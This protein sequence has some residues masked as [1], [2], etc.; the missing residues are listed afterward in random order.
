MRSREA[1]K[2]PI[3]CHHVKH[4]LRGLIGSDD[5]RRTRSRI[6]ANA[7]FRNVLTFI[8]VVKRCSP[9]FCLVVVWC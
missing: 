6:N 7:E 2:R 8:C 4:S 9:F 1:E 5:G 3:S